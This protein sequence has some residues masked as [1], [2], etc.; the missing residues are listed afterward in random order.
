MASRDAQTEDFVNSTKKAA[1]TILE[2]A[3]KDG[4]FYI[5][6]H[7]DADGIAAGGIVAKTLLRLDASFRVRITQWIDEKIIGEI[8]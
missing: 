1:E 5:F 2:N 7:L 3:Q 6:S 8:M 4:L